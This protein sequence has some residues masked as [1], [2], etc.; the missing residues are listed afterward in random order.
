MA[1]TANVP[2]R[3]PDAM[4]TRRMPLGVSRD[5]NAETTV[6]ST[7][8][9]SADPANTPRVRRWLRPGSRP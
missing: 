7:T 2:I 9:Q 3:R 1:T 6:V 4:L 5:R 8:H